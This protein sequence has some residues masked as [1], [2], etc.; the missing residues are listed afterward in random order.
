M[1]FRLLLISLLL[2]SACAAALAQTPVRQ[3]IPGADSKGQNSDSPRIGSPE[4][5]MMARQN[6]KAAEKDFREH[7]ERAREAAQL[8]AEI[9]DAF[10]TNKV[11]ARTELRKLERLEKV[12]R[13]IR[14]EAGGS[15]GDVTLE[16]PPTQLEPALTRL[17]EGAE[18]LRK[19]VEKTSRHV[20]SAA[21]IEKAN[22]VL[23]LLRYIRE[24]THP[25]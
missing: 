8:G 17:A 6:I 25:N 2:T 15:S 21:V 5:E 18:Q 22:Q 13:K 14:N 7:L 10:L 19:K 4:Q 12:T 24:I 9:R 3:G 1:L 16:D 11:L 20:I 23:E